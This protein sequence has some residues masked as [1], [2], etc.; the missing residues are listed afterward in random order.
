MTT[1]DLVGAII[2]Y[3]TCCVSSRGLAEP[4]PFTLPPL[5]RLIGEMTPIPADT[6]RTEIAEGAL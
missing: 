3:W 2:A 6:P 4:S 5:P 1:A